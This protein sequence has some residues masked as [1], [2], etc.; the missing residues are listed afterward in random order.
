MLFRSFLI[1]P[2]AGAVVVLIV[3]LTTP[4]QRLVG[5]FF[6]FAGGLAILQF[7]KAAIDIATD[8]SRKKVF[9][10][11]YRIVV[12]L[13]SD[14]VQQRRIE[15]SHPPA[16]LADRIVAA[17]RSIAEGV[18]VQRLSD[19]EF[20]AIRPRDGAL[21]AT[22]PS[23]FASKVLVTVNPKDE[24]SVVVAVE[25]RVDEPRLWNRWP[26][27]VIFDFG[28][29]IENVEEFQLALQRLLERTDES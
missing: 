29:S 17:L 2:L 19:S 14:A 21:K 28:R 18:R 25:G 22:L 11:R 9:A 24:N 23:R 3:W 4:P 27:P 20:E 26:S 10:D 12:R 7:L 1:V 15:V 13:G 5:V 8:Y 16:D 6:V